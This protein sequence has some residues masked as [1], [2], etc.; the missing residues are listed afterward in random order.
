MFALKGLY[1]VTVLCEYPTNIH[2]F[3]DIVD[4]NQ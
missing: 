1:L 3:S 2:T 4:I